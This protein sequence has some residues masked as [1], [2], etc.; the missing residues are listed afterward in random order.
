M[1]RCRHS[2][3]LSKFP[4]ALGIDDF[5]ARLEVRAPHDVACATRHALASGA[6]L[7][8]AAAPESYYSCGMPPHAPQVALSGFGFTGDNSI[9]ELCLRSCTRHARVLRTRCVATRAMP[10]GSPRLPAHPHAPFPPCSHDQP[11][12]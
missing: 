4:T 10:G 5:M 1:A 6:Q 11:V 8:L 12:P 2:A 9:G 7:V 3:I